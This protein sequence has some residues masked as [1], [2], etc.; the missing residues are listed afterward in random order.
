[1]SRG[2]K[3]LVCALIAAVTAGCTFSPE[4]ASGTLTCGE[5]NAC[6]P[7]FTCSASRVCCAPGDDRRSC[8]GDGGTPLAGGDGGVD[9][10][11]AAPVPRRLVEGA[12]D[13]IGFSESCTRARAPVSPDRWCAFTRQS[14]LWVVNVS[15]ALAGGVRCDGSDSD[16][17]RLTT[18]FYR[19]GPDRI[20]YLRP[21]FQGDLLLF[22]AE[23]LAP[24]GI[25]YRGALFA[26]YPG[27]PTARRITGP[28][29]YACSAAREAPVA[30]CV[31]RA[32]GGMFDLMFGSLASGGS[33]NRVKR[34]ATAEIAVD[35]ASTGRSLLFQELPPSGPATLWMAPLET[36]GEPVTHVA[37][38]RDAISRQW[39]F[40]PYGPRIFFLRAGTNSLGGIPGTLSTTLARNPAV[41]ADLTSRV[42]YFR[43]LVGAGGADLGVAAVQD[44]ASAA[45]IL[46]LFLGT[47]PREVVVGSSYLQFAVSPD[48][49][50]TL[51]PQLQ[52]QVT[53]R[54]DARVA[55]HE[56]GSVC[57]LQRH[58]QAVIDTEDAFSENGQLAFW[59]DYV[60]A[61]RTVPDGWLAQASSCADRR[62]FADRIRIHYV[63]RNSGLLYLD[64]F[65]ED[66]GGVLQHL[67]WG[68]E[69]SW[70]ASGPLAIQAGVD[71]A[72]TVIEPDRKIA[73]FTSH[74]SRSEGLYAVLLP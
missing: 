29:G 60:E 57:A 48:G 62:K 22:P 67:R 12:V 58:T 37:I 72:L 34:F 43:P 2:D 16:C 10:G 38:A 14:E 11:A 51:F 54:F 39:S 73:V 71:T 40:A 3:A 50:Y 61:S 4:I 63:L 65:N 15:R 56:A 64:Q 1:L 66:S 13:L 53:G 31:D 70:P 27:W 49:R 7:E 30:A 35:I 26:W 55:D 52:D 45:G 23:A 46:R 69:M 28:N 19:P 33:L 68:P 59:Y 32:E 8:A 25:S 21:E 18:A 17:L 9:G 74:R 47:P 42:H 41:I 5:G 36:A 6:P 20:A 24:E 44:M